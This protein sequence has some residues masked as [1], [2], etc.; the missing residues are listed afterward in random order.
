MKI[1][2]VGNCTFTDDTDARV[3]NPFVPLKNVLEAADVIVVSLRGSLT[4]RRASGLFQSEG[5]QLLSLKKLIPYT[6][7]IVDYKN[8]QL[9]T[10]GERGLRDT[11]RFLAKNG[12]IYNPQILRP[13]LYGTICMFHCIDAAIADSLLDKLIPISLDAISDCTLAFLRILKIYE[14]P[15]RTIIITLRIKPYN[16]NS[17]PPIVGAFCKILIESGADVVYVQARGCKPSRTCET[18]DGGMIIRGL[19]ELIDCSPSTR[20]FGSKTSELCSVDTISKLYDRK[21]I[22]KRVINDCVVPR[23]V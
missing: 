15:L 12:F 7:I 18:Y 1:L 9:L 13:L 2:F 6:P 19:G 8:P 4:S 16:T 22:R 23:R 10:L 11:E 17:L 20:L 14:A 5:Q 21:I 3:C